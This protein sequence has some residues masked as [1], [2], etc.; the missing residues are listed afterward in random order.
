MVPV[1]SDELAKNHLVLANPHLVF[2]QF[3]FFRDG[4][5]SGAACRSADVDVLAL[6]PR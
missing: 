2:V 3:V 4:S 1:N 5:A 6:A